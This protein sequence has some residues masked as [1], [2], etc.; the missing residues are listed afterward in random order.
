MLHSRGNIVSPGSSAHRKVSLVDMNG[1]LSLYR[2]LVQ[3]SQLW[4]CLLLSLSVVLQDKPVSQDQFAERLP[5]E[6]KDIW[7]LKWADVC[8]HSSLECES[9]LSSG[10][11]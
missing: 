11:L 10:A 3:R 1:I 5:L 9:G 6:R 4:S 2:I 8:Q 7:D